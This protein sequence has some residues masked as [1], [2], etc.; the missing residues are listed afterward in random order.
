MGLVAVDN[1]SYTFGP[2]FFHVSC[3]SR[4]NGGKEAEIEGEG[5]GLVSWNFNT[6]T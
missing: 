5:G 4:S 2:C 1:L 3:L 6:I